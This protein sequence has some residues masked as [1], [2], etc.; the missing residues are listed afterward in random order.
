MI[1]SNPMTES[2]HLTRLV[3][4]NLKPLVR[5]IDTDSLYPKEFL[6]QLGKEGYY[7]SDSCTKKEVFL[8]EFQLVEEVSKV[9]MTTGFVLWCQLAA[10]TYLRHTTNE[11]LKNNILP[12]LEDG[13]LLAGTGLSN[14]MKFYGGVE[15]LHLRAEKTDDGYLVSG[16]LPSVSNL[17]TDH[18]F[19]AVAS[20]ADNQRIMAFIPCQADGLTLK[21]K[22]DYLGINGSATYVCQFDQCFIPDKWIVAEDADTFISRVRPYFLMYQ[23]PLGLGVTDASVQSM[24]KVKNKQS[25]CNQYL[26]VQPED[27]KTS[28]TD[29]R[30]R[31]YRYLDR[32]SENYKWKDFAAFRLE[33]TYLTLRAVEASMIHNGGG[34]YL[35]KSN[36][37]RRLREAYFLVNLTPTVKH[38]EKILSH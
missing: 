10:L 11:F 12:K 20:T 9:C 26:P 7:A 30:N 36:P 13:S 33:I 18:W 38:L 27:L 4:K 31:V 6:H 23:I 22:T 1:K 32:G 17:G 2:N 25:A 15:K 35:Y 19:G 24:E 28:H 21:E 29:V 16:T 5:S 8:R 34:G 3:Q 37:S 14:P